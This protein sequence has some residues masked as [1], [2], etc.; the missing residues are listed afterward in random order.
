MHKLQHFVVVVVVVIAHVVC[1]INAHKKRFILWNVL[2]NVI[3]GERI[4]PSNLKVLH[5]EPHFNGANQN[6]RPSDGQ[7]GGIWV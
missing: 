2:A 1:Y 5:T 3:I 6:R 4:I 7:G